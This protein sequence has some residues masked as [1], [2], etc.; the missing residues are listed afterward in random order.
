MIKYTFIT[1]FILNFTICFSQD[2]KKN[3]Y[4]EFNE[5]PYIKSNNDSTAIEFYKL[6]FE[7]KDGIVY[8]L[9]IDNNGNLVKNVYLKG[10]S[11]KIIILKYYNV[12][13]DN[14][15]FIINLLEMKNFIT[16]NEIIDK[17]SIENFMSILENFNI[18]LVKKKS[19]NKYYAK[20]MLVEKLIGL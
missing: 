11:A 10:S 13:A 9:S 6:D 17:Y 18:Y 1:I 15:P 8:N 16:M 19:G 14:N 7:K 4:I 12:N 20:K 5:K 3:L 2:V